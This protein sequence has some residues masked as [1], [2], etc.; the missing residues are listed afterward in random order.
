MLLIGLHVEA[1]LLT[2]GMR[3][4]LLF[5]FIWAL[6]KSK[7]TSTLINSCKVTH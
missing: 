1:E 3:A 4:V 7:A 2:V 6:S 5:N